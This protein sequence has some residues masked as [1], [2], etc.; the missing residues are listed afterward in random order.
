MANLF[1]FYVLSRIE[2][3]Y[4]SIFFLSLIAQILV[5]TVL[6]EGLMRRFTKINCAVGWSGVLFGLAVWEIVHGKQVN[7]E[8]L[9]AIIA[10]VVS[11]SLKNPQASLMGHA[12]GAFAGFII[13]QF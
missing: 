11:P 3:K 2:V 12:L 13:A 7:N 8:L 9:L 10:M 5:L 6:L 4:G 1:A